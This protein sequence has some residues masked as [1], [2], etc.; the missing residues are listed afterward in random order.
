MTQLDNA[1]DDD[2]RNTRLLT[3]RWK[4]G[5]S[6][7]EA[8]ARIRLTIALIDMLVRIYIRLRSLSPWR[9]PGWR[10][11]F[12]TLIAAAVFGICMYCHWAHASDTIVGCAKKAY[13]IIVSF[14]TPA[15]PS[16]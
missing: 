11:T 16:R 15:A 2:V 5:L 14:L 1:P 8:K 10:G 7:K 4:T 3:T 9:M 6:V 12:F 13:E